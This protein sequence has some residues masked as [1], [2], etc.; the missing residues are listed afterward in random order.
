MNGCSAA[1]NL[2]QHIF[3][4]LTCGR[5]LQSILAHRGE[6]FLSFCFRH[7]H[8]LRRQLKHRRLLTA[9]QLGQENNAPIRK[10]ERIMVRPLLVLIYL[11][12]DCRRV[13]ECFDFPTDDKAGFCN[14]NRAGKREL[15]PRKNADRH[16]IVFRRSEPTR[17]GTEVLCGGFFTDLA[18]RDLTLWRL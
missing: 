1:T 12:E 2:A 17:A 4:V 10:F 5:R 9:T 8:W 14:C 13:S 15:G 18:G 11:S 6:A 16:G 3:G 7:R